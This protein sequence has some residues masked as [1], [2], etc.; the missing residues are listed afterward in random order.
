MA[1]E[2]G[3]ITVYYDGN[4]PMCTAFKEQS[5]TNTKG[6]AFLDAHTTDAPESFSKADMLA[7]MRLINAEGRVASGSDAVFI[8]LKKHRWLFWL[9]YLGL[10]PGIRQLARPVYR[11]VAKYRYWL[12]G[13]QRQ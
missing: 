6:V 3:K 1:T 4:C 12:F 9:G 2:S 13:E 10:L 5:E 11:V 7:Q 8:V